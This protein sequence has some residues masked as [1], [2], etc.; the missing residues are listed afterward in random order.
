MKLLKERE[1]SKM[2][3]AYLKKKKDVH[4]KDIQFMINSIKSALWLAKKQ[5]NWQKINCL[6]NGE[7]ISRETIHEMIYEKVKKITKK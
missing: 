3:R 2:K 7:I 1:S 4:E 5:K 6:K